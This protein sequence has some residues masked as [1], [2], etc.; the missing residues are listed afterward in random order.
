MALQFVVV[1]PLIAGIDEYFSREYKFNIK[2]KVANDPLKCVIE[3]TKR[4]EKEIYQGL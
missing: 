4:I 1:V 2:V 3:G